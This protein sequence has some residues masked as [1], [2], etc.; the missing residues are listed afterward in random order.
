MN[1]ELIEKTEH[2]LKCGWKWK[3][4]PGIGKILSCPDNETYPLKQVSKNIFIPEFIK[5]ERSSNIS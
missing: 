3:D 2:L 4:V 1:I 5:L